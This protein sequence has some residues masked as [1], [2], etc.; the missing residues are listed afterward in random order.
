VNVRA[1]ERFMDPETGKFNLAHAKPLVYNHGFYYS[2]G[3][4][5]GKFGWS[6]EKKKK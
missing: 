2:L 4:E 5:I 6:V 3:K 1:D